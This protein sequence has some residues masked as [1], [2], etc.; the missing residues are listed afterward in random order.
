MKVEPKFLKKILRAII[1]TRQDEIGCHECF[2]LLDQFVEMELAGKTP[3]E[4]L[5]LVE[6]HLNRCGNC[7]EEYEA[8]LAALRAVV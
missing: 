8:L 6:D 2:E 7:K 4:A 3:G 5:P 1:N